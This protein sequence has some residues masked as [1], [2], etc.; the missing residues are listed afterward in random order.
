MHSTRCA[1]SITPD[2]YARK[3]SVRARNAIKSPDNAISYL[4]VHPPLWASLP[5]D[6]LTYRVSHGYTAGWVLPHHTRT[7]RNHYLWRVIP[8][9]TCYWHGAL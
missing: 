2:I 3:L 6:P 8:I 9:M 1:I 5:N 7:S 4:P